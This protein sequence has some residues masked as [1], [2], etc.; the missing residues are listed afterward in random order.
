MGEEKCEKMKR[1]KE[2]SK[3]RK[4]RHFPPFFLFIKSPIPDRGRTLQ[5]FDIQKK[6]YFVKRRFKR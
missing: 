4:N 3:E 2:S 1:K 6:I 5:A